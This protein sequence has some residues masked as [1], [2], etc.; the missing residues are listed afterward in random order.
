MQVVT[1]SAYLEVLALEL[2]GSG[3]PFLPAD[4]QWKDSVHAVVTMLLLC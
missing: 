1:S 2:V 4:P 3:L